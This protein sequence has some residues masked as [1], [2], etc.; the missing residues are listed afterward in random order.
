MLTSLPRDQRGPLRILFMLT[1]MEVGGAETLLVNLIR[2]LDPTRC[3]AEVCCL[4][5]P[6]PLGEEISR[7][8]PLHSNLIHGKYDLGVVR[9]L[10]E[11]L[12]EQSVDAVVTVGCGDKMFWGRLAAWRAG[13][14]VVVSALHST[15]WPDGVGWLNH[16]LNAI[17]DAFVA[18]AA[19]HGRHLI[20][21]E[22]FPRQKVV[23]IPNGI[24]VARFHN[25][26]TDV[27][28]QRQLLGLPVHGPLGVMVAAL[29]PEKNHR[30]FIRVAR[31]VIGQIPMAQFA[32]VGDGPIRAEL[33]EYAL[34]QGVSD[35]IHFLGSRA[36]VP[37]ILRA[38]DVF[39]LTS[40]NEAAPVS[41]LEASASGLPVIAPDVGSIR[42]LVL[43]GKTGYVLP[44]NDELFAQRIVDLFDD[45][46]L[47]ETMGAEGREHVVGH[48][49]LEVM[50]EGYQSL[51]ERIYDSK[52]APAH[53]QPA[54]SLSPA[55]H[56][57]TLLGTDQPV[58][59]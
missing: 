17:T 23:V 55:I 32:I 34:E 41:I 47:L 26:C 36:D 51:I 52:V 13:T 2:S 44:H 12:T 29:R 8:I 57:S 27:V 50:T 30:R 1:S 4:K 38:S 7:E 42:E 54:R 25:Q 35:A 31:R 3:V 53:P 59:H 16:R 10:T 24:D 49:S 18:V 11:L 33:E 9:R 43:D 45:S 58:P 21:N 56:A 22:R 39:V 40:D 6:G 28:R 15:G 5:D 46:D 48:G 37:E 19:A 14:P 20:E